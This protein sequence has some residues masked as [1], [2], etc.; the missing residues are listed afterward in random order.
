MLS[1]NKQFARGFLCKH[2][3][4]LQ[5][6][7]QGPVAGSGECSNEPPGSGVTVRELKPLPNIYDHARTKLN[8]LPTAICSDKSLYFRI[9]MLI[10]PEE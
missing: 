2:Y 10:V 3:N 7:P 4:P 6:Q 9:I 8:F 5:L 1:E